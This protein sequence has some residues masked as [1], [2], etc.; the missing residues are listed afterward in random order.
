M[1]EGTQEKIKIIT[2]K[3]KKCFVL[4]Y[5]F[6]IHTGKIKI[7]QQIKQLSCFI[8]IQNDKHSLSF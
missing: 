2:R 1:K 3:I 4:N 6:N 5:V 8:L 7:K